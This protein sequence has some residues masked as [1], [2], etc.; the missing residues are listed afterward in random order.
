MNNLN[1]IRRIQTEIKDLFENTLEDNGI[2][3]ELNNEDINVIKVMMIGTKNTPYENGFFFFSIRFPDN[4]PSSPVKV[5]YY[6]THPSMRFNPNL[7]NNG[8]VCLSIINT[9]GRTDNW[10][11]QMTVKGVILSIQS[12]V[13]TEQPLKNEPGLQV[14]TER[15]ENYNDVLKYCVFNVGIYQVLTKPVTNLLEG[16]SVTLVSDGPV[17]NSENTI[18]FECFQ[19]VIEKHFIDNIKW[20]I[21]ELMKL[22]FKNEKRILTFNKPFSQYRF[23]C[24]YDEL[25]IKYKEHYKKLTDNDVS[26]IEN[27]KINIDNIN[28]N[29]LKKLQ[30]VNICR[31][32]KFKGFSNKN[33]ENLIKLIYEKSVNNEILL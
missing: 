10:T 17:I 29:K 1:R 11:D 23:K 4:Y 21:H 24:N 20:Y 8:K 14:T 3:Y 25:I 19:S 2:Y 18:S 32:N 31:T 7:Y 28:I 16:S 5:W 22:D 12:M 27:I 33:K 6:T 9:W 26:G 15:I 13:L 30:L